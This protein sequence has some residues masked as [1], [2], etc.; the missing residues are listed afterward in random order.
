[1]K[2]FWLMVS[3]ASVA[4][5][6]LFTTALYL[7][8]CATLTFLGRITKARTQIM[9]YYIVNGLV[10]AVGLVSVLVVSVACPSESYY[11]N[12]HDNRVNLDCPS[13]VCTER[14]TSCSDPTDFVLRASDGRHSP[15]WTS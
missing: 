13:Q 5:T 4:G 10:A 8:K 12:F 7:T 2:T 1:M 9:F 15:D 14:D 11:W 3:Q 6:V